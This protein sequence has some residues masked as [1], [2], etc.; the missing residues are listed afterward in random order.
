MKKILVIMLFASIFLLACAGETSSTSDFE[1]RGYASTEKLVS[2]KW[3]NEN[4]D[5]KA[6]IY[7]YNV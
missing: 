2:A 3:L 4:L 5:K 7:R 6:I 1:N